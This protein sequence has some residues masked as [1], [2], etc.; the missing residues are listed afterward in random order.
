MLT[1]TSL[2]EPQKAYLAGFIDGEGYVGLTFQIK[3]ETSQNSATP[4]YHPYLIIANNNSPVLFHIKD[5]IGEGKIYELKRSSRN[6]KPGFQYKLTKM[7]TLET[8]LPA[9]EPYLIVKKQQAKLLIRYLNTRRSKR[10]TT[11]TGSRGATS[12]DRAEEQIHQELLLLNKK[13][14]D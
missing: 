11:G 3:K 9:I 8:L 5:I 14:V 6:Q 1:G 12:F 7:S 13:G 2:T 4:R 10:I